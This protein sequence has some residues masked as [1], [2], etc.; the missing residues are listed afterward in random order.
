MKR[1]FL[2][3]V[4][5]LISMLSLKSFAIVETK[6]ISMEEAIKTALNTNPQIKILKLETEI[7]TNDIKIANR[8]NN[9]SLNAFQNLGTGGRGE[10]QHIGAD[11][12]VEILKRSFRKQSATA[13]E[14]SARNSQ[15]YLEYNLVLEVKKTYIDLLLK[16]TNYK[17]VLEQEKLSK[18]LLENL[19]K[20]TKAKKLPNT[21][22]VQAKIAYNRAL[23]YSNIAKSEVISAQN[24][25]NSIMNSYKIDYDTKQ[26]VLSDNYEEFLA[27]APDN[28]GIA[29]EDIKNYTLTHRFDYLASQND[30][31]TAES[32]L[33]EV[34][35]KLIP[36]LE[37][38]AGYQYRPRGGSSSGTLESGSYIGA[39]IVNLPIFYAYKPEIKNAKLEI[40]KAK[41]RNED[42]KI[43]IIR[44]ITDAWEKYT[45]SKDNL[46]FYN[47]ELLL[48]SKE[49]LNASYKN[50]NNKEIDLTSF[51]VSK[52]LYLELILGYNQALGDYYVSYYELL[53]RMNSEDLNI[54]RDI[55]KI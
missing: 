13:K 42:L 47:K 10:P 18:E 8:L 27:I 25:F 31:E 9:P 30:L 46:N 53:C 21:E 20:E 52:K 39:S 26:D 44:E 54:K 51:L 2:I 17:I 23:M 15:R 36:D 41:L 24:S 14:N 49:L 40:E 12:A 29:F 35:S 48:N 38:E 34:K 11:I 50:L 6:K 55:E 43:D 28:T 3:C 16:K 1:Y 7:K 4:L 19:E 45:I 37:L 32:K 33:N 22:I 5:F